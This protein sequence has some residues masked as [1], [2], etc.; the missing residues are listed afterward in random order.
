MAE[1]LGGIVTVPKDRLRFGVVGGVAENADLLAPWI[2][3]VRSF[4][5]HAGIA[6]REVMFVAAF[7]ELGALST[8]TG[9]CI[10][11]NNNQKQ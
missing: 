3:S 6:E 4:V 1:G 9:A 10:E 11:K 5:V 2:G 7:R 8:K